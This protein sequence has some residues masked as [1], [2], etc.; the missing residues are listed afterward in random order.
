MTPSIRETIMSKPTWNIRE[1]LASEAFL[2]NPSESKEIRNHREHGTIELAKDLVT[3]LIDVSRVFYTTLFG[4]LDSAAAIPDDK[5]EEA[6]KEYGS[7][8]FR[9][10]VRNDPN[11][12]GVFK[13]I[14]DSEVQYIENHML[15]VIAKSALFYQIKAVLALRDEVKQYNS[16]DEAIHF[17]KRKYNHDLIPY[18]PDGDGVTHI[19]VYSK[20]KTELG[21]LLSN[22]AHTPF[23][24]YKHGHF[25]SIEA[26]WY[27]LST[28]MTHDEL[29]GLYGFDAKKLGLALR[30]AAGDVERPLVKDFNAMIKQ[31][32]L[33][34]IEST[35]KLRE[36]LHYSELPLTHY[37]V[38]GKGEDYKITY[39]IQHNF[40]YEYMEVVRRWLNGKAHKVLISG[41][42]SIWDYDFVKKCHLESGVEAVEFISGMAKGPDR[43]CLKLAS[44]L[45]IPVREFPANWTEHGKG[46]GFIRNR[47]MADYCTFAEVHWDGH[48]PGTKNQIELL[49][50]E[51]I[52]FKVFRHEPF[53]G[54]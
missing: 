15:P 17:M 49:T 41:S 50:E 22:F 54:Q 19:N 18:E 46:A 16:Y 37:Y 28:G 10:F 44:E 32:I 52:D 2:S 29:R 42:R 12:D 45:E 20:G 27:W 31:A 33:I 14:T 9:M 40:L 11:F 7:V 13:K 48:S 51:K 39:P 25:S 35:P 26:Y 47:L 4:D 53:T 1:L 21:R 43:L 6:S 30:T 36:L 34:K 38:W 8:L 23:E 24:H 3:A 5:A